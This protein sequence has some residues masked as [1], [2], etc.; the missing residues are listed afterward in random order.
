[1]LDPQNLVNLTGGIVADPE[2]VNGRIFKT[3]LAIDYAGSEK[4]SDN[5]SGY[6]EI[7]YYLK[8]NTGFTSSN[9]SFVATQVEQGKLKKGST[10]SLIG[11]LV[12]ERW[13]S[14]GKNNSRVT[15]V[16]EHLSYAK[17]SRS[18]NPSSST[19]SDS[20]VGNTV[21]VSTNSVPSSF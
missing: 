15:V 5:N 8:N 14:D 1:M 20:S 17:S 18:S 19:A 9:A 21:A 7:V 16:V 3:R 2:I 12:Q 11:R 6:F 4:D 10:V 13:K